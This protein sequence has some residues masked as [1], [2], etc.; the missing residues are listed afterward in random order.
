MKA[1]LSVILMVFS[2]C[3]PEFAFS[4]GYKTPLKQVELIKN[5]PA[6]LRD[7]PAD[8]PKVVFYFLKKAPGASCGLL[9]SLA[10]STEITPIVETEMGENFPFCFDVTQGA[11]FKFHDSKYWVFKYSQQD[12][13]EDTSTSYF[14]VQQNGED[15]QPVDELNNEITPNDKTIQYMA[16]W[17]KF[18]MVSYENSPY[19][20]SESNSIITESAFLNVSHDDSTKTCRVIADYVT[21]NN[22]A[23]S[24]T[25][26]CESILA[27][28][29]L[30][31]SNSIYFIVLYQ[32]DARKTGGLIFVRRGNIFQEAVD[33]EKKFIIQIES[34]QILKVKESLRKWVKSH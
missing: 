27:T 23:E 30:K 10:N 7:L 9:P 4:T 19:K 17:A 16:A 1:I 11:E 6:K 25:V 21:T 18:K 32:I 5:N 28:T 29:A 13:R 31:T 33:L 2:L 24:K 20:V 26:P 34:K 8:A 14:F 3:S 22:V 15:L 12:T